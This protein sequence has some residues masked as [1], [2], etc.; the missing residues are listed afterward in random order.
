M[1]RLAPI[2]LMF[3]ILASQ[4]TVFPRNIEI[5]MFPL[6]NGEFDI[7]IELGKDWKGGDLIIKEVEIYFMKKV[8][9]IRYSSELY[10]SNAK[11]GN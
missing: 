11:I 4:S 2:S 7:S 1:R 9:D 3:I 6:S 10:R 8:T 5:S